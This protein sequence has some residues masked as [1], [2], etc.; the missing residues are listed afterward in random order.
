VPD[1]TR[2]LNAFA[3]GD[4]SA[5]RRLLTVVYEELRQ[6]AGAHLRHERSNQTLQATDLVHEAYLRLFAGVDPTFQ[7]RAHFFAA[8]GEAM[9][10]I[11]VE[12]ARRRSQAKRGGGWGRLSFNNLPSFAAAGGA[13]PADVLAVHEALLKLEALDARAAD[14]VKLRCF[15]GMSISQV[16]Q[17]LGLSSRTVNRDWQVA[18]AW[19]SRQLAGVTP[20]SAV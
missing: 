19:L 18:R 15:I 7:N 3:S 20:K 6:M 2:I 10:R 14:I 12:R 4:D 11:L 1:V 16:A 9:R 17:S 13:D 5:G 8:A